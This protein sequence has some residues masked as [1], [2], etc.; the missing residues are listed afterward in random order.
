MAEAFYVVA[1]SL[2]GQLRSQEGVGGNAQGALVLPPAR[3]IPSV[4]LGRAAFLFLT[5]LSI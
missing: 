1:F 4:E 2:T 3:N 5:S